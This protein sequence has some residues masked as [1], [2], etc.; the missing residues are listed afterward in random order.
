MLSDQII[1]QAWRQ[2]IADL[3]KN[4]TIPQTR[5]YTVHCEILMSQNNMKRVL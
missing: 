2:M 4:P 1:L 5:R 3:T